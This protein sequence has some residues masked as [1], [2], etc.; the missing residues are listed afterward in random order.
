MSTTG[1]K[2]GS[3]RLSQKVGRFHSSST[4]TH[5][6]PL[7]Y[8]PC[9]S[10]TLAERSFPVR[11]GTRSAE[12]SWKSF[13]PRADVCIAERERHSYSLHPKLLFQAHL[14]RTALRIKVSLSERG[15]QRGTFESLSEKKKKWRANGSEHTS[16]VRAHH[17]PWAHQGAYYLN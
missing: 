10:E 8:P 5:R 4:L 13:H 7:F 14:L 15:T 17:R 9:R 16:R 2:L 11:R 1:S 12:N 6:E 3:L